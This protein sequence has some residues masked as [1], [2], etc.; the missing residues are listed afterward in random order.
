[1][2]PLMD[3]RSYNQTAWN[4]NVDQGNR[5]TQPVK[6]E[7]IEKARS[8]ELEV[9]LT[10][11]RPVPKQWFPD[12]RGTPT[13]CLAAAGGQQAPLL[14]AAGAVV[15]VLD[16]S[17]RQ[18]DQDRFVAQRDGLALDLVEGDMADLSVFPD[19]SFS[20]VFHPCSNAFVPSVRPVWREC[21]RVLRR[22]G[23]LLAG[24][25]NPLRYIFDGERM[26]HGNLEVCYSVPYS[27]LDHRS[28]P[29]VRSIIDAGEPLEFG[30]TLEDQIGGQLIAGFV[31]T[32][33]Y[34]DRYGEADNDPLSRHLAS[35]I[36]TRASKP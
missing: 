13:L 35:F 24:F 11:T 30:H 7:A 26:E 21:F 5:W 1:M 10:P 33:F 22:G 15:T 16:N 36:A 31:L 8:G 23:I 4:R 6:A 20:L 25:T 3:I 27:D 9:V 34:E 14:A 32:G 17:P 2:E 28:D 19:E 12:L 29:H 18:L